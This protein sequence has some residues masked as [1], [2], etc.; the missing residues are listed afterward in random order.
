MAVVIRYPTYKIIKNT[1]TWKPL[2]RR[3]ETLL[4]KLDLSETMNRK[5]SKFLF[6]RLLDMG[7]TTIGMI[8]TENN[9][10]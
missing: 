1:I 7:K 10:H 9:F 8:M 5:L 2:F 6:L 3:K 4:S